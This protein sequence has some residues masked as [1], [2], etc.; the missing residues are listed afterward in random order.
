MS[1]KLYFPERAMGSQTTDQTDLAGVD[2]VTVLQA[3]SDPVRL[4]IVRQ[5]ACDPAGSM[6]CG[7][8]QLEVTKS[9]ASHHLKALRCA[10]VIAQ[11]DEGTRRY[12]WLRR[13]DL[14]ARFPGLI[15]AVLKAAVTD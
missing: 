5:L 14:E 8:I 3:L 11:R 4:E 6:P 7:Q 15:D 2:L 10:G 9:T 12:T 13:D 1:V